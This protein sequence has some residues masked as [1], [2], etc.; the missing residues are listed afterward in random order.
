MGWTSYL[1][2]ITERLTDDLSTVEKVLENPALPESAK[3]DALLKWHGEAKRVLLELRR[4]MDVATDPDLDLAA[5]VIALERR[6]SDLIAENSRLEIERKRHQAETEKLR[7]S[8]TQLQS[9][10]DNLKDAVKRERKRND[11][12]QDALEA[13]PTPLYEKYTS[14]DRLKR[15]LKDDD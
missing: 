15:Y 12:L 14:P 10:I 1:E 11:K 13:D 6:R 8:H 9:Q 4:D 5:E 7:E 2:D 3:L